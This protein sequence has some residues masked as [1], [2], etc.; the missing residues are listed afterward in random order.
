MFFQIKSC[1]YVCLRACM[2]GIITHFWRPPPPAS[3]S[4]PCLYSQPDAWQAH[5]RDTLNI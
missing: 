2:C 3:K 5:L 4:N 1:V